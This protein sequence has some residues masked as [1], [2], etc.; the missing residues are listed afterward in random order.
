MILKA[1]YI[2]LKRSL[3]LG[4]L[5]QMTCVTMVFGGVMIRVGPR[6]IFLSMLSELFPYCLTFV[7]LFHLSGWVFSTRWSKKKEIQVSQ[8]FCLSQKSL[9]MGLPIA[10]ILFAES[11]ENLFSI[12]LPLFCVHFLQLLVG[13]LFLNVWKRRVVATENGKWKI[14]C[15]YLIKFQWRTESDL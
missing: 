7:L 8:F 9:A 5:F 15:W 11:E 12:T 2:I 1:W 3:N 10:S 4:I 6:K 14:W 13:T